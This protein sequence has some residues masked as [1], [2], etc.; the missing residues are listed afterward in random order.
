MLQFLECGQQIC[1]RSAPT[2]QPPNQHYIDLSATPGSR[3]STYAW[4]VRQE[5]ALAQ[6][7]MKIRLAEILKLLS[8]RN[9]KHSTN[10]NQHYTIGT[11]THFC[12]DQDVP[13]Q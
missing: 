8:T 1:Y 13:D 9:P 5:A 10:F 12:D 4:G 6:R 11:P 3:P 7:T 2:V